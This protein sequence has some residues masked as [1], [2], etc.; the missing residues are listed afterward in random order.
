MAVVLTAIMIVFIIAWFICFANQSGITVNGRIGTFITEKRTCQGEGVSRRDILYIFVIALIFRI[1]VYIASVVYLN[2]FSDETTFGFSD[3][4]S[5]WNRWDA[6]HYIDLAKKGYEGYVENGQ[7]LFLVFFPLYPWLLRALHVVIRDWEIACLVL[8]CLAYAAGACFF[9]ALV[10]EEYGKRIAWKSLVLLSVYPFSF[11]FGGMMTESLFLCTMM[12]GFYFV[13]KHN[14]LATG[15]TGI[16]C[17]LC[18]VQGV[19]LFGVA[20]VEF[21]VYY[22]PFKMFKEKEGKEFIK[23][24]FTKGICLFLIPVGNL[25]YFYIN[26]RVEGN[27]FQF[28]VYQKEHWYHGT[29][30]FTN[31]L[32]EIWGYAFGESTQNTM[33]ASVWIP[34]L[35]LFAVTIILLFYGLRRHPLKYTA[36][37]LVY[38]IVNYSVTFLISGGRY[39]SCAFPLFIILGEML[40]RHPKLYNMVVAVSSM[41]FAIYMAGYFSW[42]QIM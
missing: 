14:W 25:I 20:G 12:A 28:S 9:Y 11:F 10:S 30:Y 32:S 4:L 6:P 3:F 26:Y 18:R 13:K 7:H 16:L 22:K 8:S 24:L 34:E 35:V 36:F 33:A 17:S 31:A 39:M 19:L 23:L 2:I 37:L 5:A 40:D 42:K 21:F 27:P 1:A 29:T 41:L 38:T 15:L